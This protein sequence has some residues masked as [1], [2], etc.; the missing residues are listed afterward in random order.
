MMSAEAREE[1][2]NDVD[3]TNSMQQEGVPEGE[4][5]TNYTRSFDVSIGTPGFDLDVTGHSHTWDYHNAN[6]DDPHSAAAA[7]N[8]HYNVTSIELF[9]DLVMVVAIHVCAEPLEES[10]EF[11]ISI[12]W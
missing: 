4:L 6:P 3:R 12:P 2:G 8:V 11:L 9:S 5:V 1:D 10:N 7:E